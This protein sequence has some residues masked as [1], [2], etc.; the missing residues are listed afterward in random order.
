MGLRA[1]ARRAGRYVARRHVIS[2]AATDPERG[3]QNTRANVLAG[4]D[5]A[6]TP[7]A[8]RSTCT[9]PGG[10]SVSPHCRIVPIER[11]P[12]SVV[13]LTFNEEQNLAACLKSVA[14]W[15]A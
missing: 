14:G 8:L 11:V 1:D 7:R 6:A 3:G 2:N 4:D 9:S 13:V 5:R 10:D 12:L 15:A